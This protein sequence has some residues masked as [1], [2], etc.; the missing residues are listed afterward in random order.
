MEV[1]AGGGCALDFFFDAAASA[2]TGMQVPSCLQPIPTCGDQGTQPLGKLHREA[3][4]IKFFVD[5]PG[6]CDHAMFQLRQR[7]QP[8]RV[9]ASFLFLSPQP[10]N[11]RLVEEPEEAP[12]ETLKS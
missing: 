7:L 6:S 8:W 9:R 11:R 10:G 5:V 2:P 4:D 1:V 12:S 3:L